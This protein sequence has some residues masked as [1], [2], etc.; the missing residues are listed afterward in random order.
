MNSDADELNGY[1][2]EYLQS[3]QQQD[4]VEGWATSMFLPSDNIDIEGTPKNARRV[5]L[6]A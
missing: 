6:T 1:L 5:P 2:G 4:P 3:F